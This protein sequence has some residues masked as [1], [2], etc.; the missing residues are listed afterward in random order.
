MKYRSEIPNAFHFLSE[1]SLLKRVDGNYMSTSRWQAA[2]AKASFKIF[3]Q[4]EKP[5]DIRVPI[6]MSLNEL[7]KNEAISKDEM[8][9]LIAAM[10]EVEA[11]T[12][13]LTYLNKPV[14]FPFLYR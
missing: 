12:L 8:V 10:M 4:Q 13:G 9:S 2:M 5:E 3:N 14:K 6:A 11:R 1:R 7:L